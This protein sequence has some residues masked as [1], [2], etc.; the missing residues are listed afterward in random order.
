M[1]RIAYIFKDADPA[2]GSTVAGLY[3]GEQISLPRMGQAITIFNSV[4]SVETDGYVSDLHR[5][6]HTYDVDIPDGKWH[7]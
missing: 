7:T 5:T 4:T 6:T 3:P 2:P 1:T